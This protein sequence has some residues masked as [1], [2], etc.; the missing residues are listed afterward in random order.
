MTKYFRCY[1]CDF[2]TNIDRTYQNH[3]EQNHPSKSPHP[4]LRQIKE[5][6]LKK[7]GKSGKK[8]EFNN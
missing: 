8:W 3:V 1:Y 6:G 4:T 7:Q 5:L 2:E